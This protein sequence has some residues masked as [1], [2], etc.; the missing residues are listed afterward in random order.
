[1]EKLDYDTDFDYWLSMVEARTNLLRLESKIKDNDVENYKINL[2]LI[3]ISSELSSRIGKDGRATFKT[4][5]E[6][7]KPIWAAGRNGT[8]PNDLNSVD[9]M[10]GWISFLETSKRLQALGYSISS[11]YTLLLEKIC[12]HSISNLLKLRF[13]TSS[14][15]KLEQLDEFFRNVKFNDRKPV[16]AAS[17]IREFKCF[18]C[19]KVGHYAR[20]CR[21]QCKD[22][23]DRHP[24]KMCPKRSKN[25]VSPSLDQ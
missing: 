6:K 12:D 8:S 20:N 4:L 9:S 18:N 15:T 3:N 17:K 25:F 5:I 21:A 16:M 13:L 23:N 7:L 24:R 22:C 2:A 19:E 11:I 1:M 10:D 14:P